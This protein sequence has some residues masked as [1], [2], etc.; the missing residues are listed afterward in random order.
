MQDLER[1]IHILGSHQLPEEPEEF[2]LLALKALG[3]GEGEKRELNLFPAHRLCQVPGSLWAS[4][5]QR[6]AP[7]PSKAQSS[8]R[9]GVPVLEPELGVA[10]PAEVRDQWPERCRVRHSG[11]LLEASGLS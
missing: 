8:I 11:W 5:P 4:V 6:P 2:T 10:G 9:G 3:E 1:N 7:D